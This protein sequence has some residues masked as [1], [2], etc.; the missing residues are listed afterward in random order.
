M[1]GFVKEIPAL[2]R[3]NF[4]NLR[5]RRGKSFSLR[6]C[7]PFA[8]RDEMQRPFQGGCLQIIH[9][10]A[11]GRQSNSFLDENYVDASHVHETLSRG[12]LKEAAFSLYSI[13]FS[14]DRA[15]FLGLRP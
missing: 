14:L 6:E 11:A 2:N 3:P 9:D 4:L 5:P 13:F 8:L 7:Q 1:E 10:V 15:N 12:H